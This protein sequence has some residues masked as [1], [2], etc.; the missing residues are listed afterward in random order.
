[1]KILKSKKGI[2]LEN[3]LLFMMVIFSLCFLVS[4]FALI[5][6]YQGEIENIKIAQR[7]ELDQIGEN[8]IADARSADASSFTEQP[9]TLGNYTCKAENRVLTVWHKNDAEKNVMLYVEVDD[10]GNVMVWRY[11]SPN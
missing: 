3:A 8:F 9:T 7:A 5:G 11:S 2:A 4:S 10:T 6:H 1:M